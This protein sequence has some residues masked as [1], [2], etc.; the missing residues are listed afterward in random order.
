MSGT[1][2]LGVAIIAALPPTIVAVGAWRS[3]HNAH[4]EIK[5]NDGK[6]AGD[7]VE[8]S[9]K[10]IDR[11]EEQ[12]HL[13]TARHRALANTSNDGIFETDAKGYY[14]WV[15]AGWTA[16]TGLGLDQAVGRGWMA[17]V[18]PDDRT[19]V[20]DAWDQSITDGRSFGP[21]TFRLIN[22]MSV[23]ITMVHQ[24]ASVVRNSDGDINGWVGTVIPVSVVK[25][26]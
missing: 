5:T 1:T 3:S 26:A 16:L 2:Q 7:Y 11:L 13:L 15:S 17:A 20:S 24:R 10:A 12:V 14:T 23:A 25:P 8:S 4:K 18:H 19:M 9:A 6:R 21:M 22:S